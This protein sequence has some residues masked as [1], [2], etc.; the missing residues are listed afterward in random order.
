MADLINLMRHF[1]LHC[2]ICVGSDHFVHTHFF[3]KYLNF[4]GVFYLFLIWCHLVTFMAKIRMS[5]VGTVCANAQY[6]A[7]LFQLCNTY[8]EHI[9]LNSDALL[10]K[11]W[12]VLHF[13]I[14][15]CLTRC[16]CVCVCGGGGGCG[17]A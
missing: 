10:S 1:L 13:S 14:A 6:R 2:V 8:I 3:E 7:P 16:V 17:F 4:F 11:D 12:P 15:V 9:P 5:V